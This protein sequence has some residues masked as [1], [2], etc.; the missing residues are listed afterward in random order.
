MSAASE[1]AYQKIRG[2]ISDGT[3]T[4]GARLKEA[5]LV[6]LCNVSRTPVREAL[7]RLETEGMVTIT[8]NAGAI[9][10]VWSQEDLADLYDLRARIEA[11]AARYAAAR[12]T[13]SDIDTLV[14]HAEAMLQ[15]VEVSGTGDIDQIA[16][17]N[18]GFHQA[19]IH[20]AR[21]RALLATAG[22]IVEPPLM[23]RTF[24]RYD[25]ERLKRSAMQHLEIAQAIARGDGEWAGAVMNA[26]IRA[27]YQALLSRAERP[28]DDGGG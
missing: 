4:S 3:L 12:R 1:R 21:S 13:R 22:Q 28:G 2:R 11:M 26:H 5:E 6:K 16:Q 27:G 24:R 8:P 10:A 19:V 25:I 9:V 18:H 7:R 20:A 15:K 23:L 17:L 14:S